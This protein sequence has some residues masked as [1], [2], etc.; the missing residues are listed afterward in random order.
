MFYGIPPEKI[1]DFRQAMDILATVYPASIYGNDMLIT[2]GR[3]LSFRSDEWFMNSFNS[4]AHSDQQKSLLWRLHVLTWAAKNALNLDGDFVECGVL[5]GFCS[6]VIR[7]YIQFQEIPKQYFLYDTFSGLPEET[8]TEVE[9][10]QYPS[11]Q[12]IEGDE[13]YREVCEKFSAYNNVRIIRGIVPNSF[14]E[15]VPRK[16][17]FLH[18]DMNFEKAEI[19][20][21]ERLFDK[22][23]PGGIVILDG[24]VG[25]AP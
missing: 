11:Y 6:E 19:L 5:K 4:S 10:N 21:L 14:E 15:A 16:I 20:D 9:R 23:V 18:L 8:S 13:L 7:K 3:N 12:K 24:L 22:L 1:P 17:A 25:I 2:I